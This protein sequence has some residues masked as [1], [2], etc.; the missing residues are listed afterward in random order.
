VGTPPLIGR[1]QLEH[2]DLVIFPRTGEVRLNTLGAVVLP[3]QW[4]NSGCGAGPQA[5]WLS[6]GLIEIEGQGTPTRALP[7]GVLK[8]SQQI[9]AAAAKHS[10]PPQFVAGIMGLE[11]GGNPNA[12]SPANAWGLMQLL[13]ST[14]SGQAGRLVTGQELL[15][16]PLLNLDLGTKFLAE[17]WEKYKGN[18]IRVTASYN[19]GSPKCGMGK[20]CD[21]PNRW[22]LITDCPTGQNGVRRSVD[23]PGRVIEYSNSALAELGPAASPVTTRSR[24]T[25][26][27]LVTG[28]LIGG[29]ALAYYLW[30]AA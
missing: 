27:P 19:A 17:L 18:A 23:Y 22:N 16:D 13:P 9:R 10:L 25:A 21:E 12:K 8:W 4:F 11:S 2:L 20:T 6:N 24:A 30:R 29:A 15:D 5:R 1:K 28:L 26:S 14:A 7:G 3:G